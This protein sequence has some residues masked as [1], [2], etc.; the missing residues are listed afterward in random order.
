MLATSLVQYPEHDEFAYLG[1]ALYGSGLHSGSGMSYN[2][3]NYSVSYIE[4]PPLFW[5][6]LTS[7]FSLGVSPYSALVISPL[8]TALNAVLVCLFAYELTRDLKS[9][10]FAGILAG[11]SGFAISIGSHILSDAMGS[12]LAALAMFSFYEYVFKNRR[13]FAL[14]TGAAIGLGLV[15]RDEDLVTLVLL[16]VLWIIFVPKGGAVRKFL[17]LFV[18][19]VVVG[20]PLLLYG[21]NM[22]AYETAVLQLISNLATPI[23]FSWWPVIVGIGAFLTFIAYRS[24]NRTRFAELGAG[25]FAFFVV[26]LPFFFDNYTLG[27]VDYY[28]AGKGILARPV[29]HLMMIP[30]TGNVGAHLTTTA[31]MLDWL[32]SMPALL[33]I[34]VIISAALGIYFLARSN[35]KD[36]LFLFLWTLVT[37]GFVVVGTNLEDRFLLIAFAPI[38]IFAGVGL[39]NIWKRNYA[40]GVVFGSATVVLADIIPRSTI[41]LSNL[42]IVASLTTHKS[43][44]LYGFLSTITL[45][46]PSPV[47]PIS[48]IAEGLLSLPFAILALMV[49]ANV[50]YSK[51]GKAASVSRLLPNGLL[52][53]PTNKLVQ[54]KRSLERQTENDDSLPEE[55]EIE[56]TEGKEIKNEQFSQ[57]INQPVNEGYNHLAPEYSKA[58][59]STQQLKAP[60]EKPLWRFS[61]GEDDAETGWLFES[62]KTDNQGS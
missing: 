2:G 43:N 32:K 21:M 34:P 13:W 49:S 22:N 27:N 42:T 31:R 54:W 24:S 46:S 15:A 14:I 1:N 56:V 3:E 28:I 4:R 45:N 48:L 58:N 38:M 18:L 59:Q 17:Y 50:V 61:G 20:A 44:W 35:R 9:G 47:L 7:L 26:M 39:G 41:S 53:V 6:L 23:V 33:S 36:F 55:E 60:P 19:G 29:S 40:L 57:E 8:F 10:I 5:W 37:F 30:A 25:F 51:P 12:F 16:I 62:E 11:V 52:R